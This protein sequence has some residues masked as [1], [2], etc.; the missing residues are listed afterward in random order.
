M[1]DWNRTLAS[2]AWDQICGQ[3]ETRSTSDEIA[4]PRCGHLIRDLWEYQIEDGDTATDVCGECGEGFEIVK[5]VSVSYTARVSERA[6][7][8]IEE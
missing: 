1:T 7:P 3:A 5:R 8:A 2:K 6:T 4:C